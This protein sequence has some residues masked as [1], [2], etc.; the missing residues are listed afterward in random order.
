MFDAFKHAVLVGEL[1]HLGH[2]DGVPTG[3]VE[4]Q[5]GAGVPILRWQFLSEP[6]RQILY[7][8]IEDLVDGFQAYIGERIYGFALRDN[9]C[10]L[11]YWF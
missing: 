3:Q 4:L 9:E 7:L 11:E 8:E 1:D 10:A 6:K 5:S 2:A